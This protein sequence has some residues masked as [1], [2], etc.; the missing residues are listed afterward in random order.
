MQGQKDLLFILLTG[1]MEVK[2]RNVLWAPSLTPRAVCTSP[3]GSWKLLPLIIPNKKSSRPLKATLWDLCLSL[4]GFC[5][6]NFNPQEETGLG[7]GHCSLVHTRGRGGRERGEP[8]NEPR[9]L[10]GMALPSSGALWLDPGEQPIFTAWSALLNTSPGCVIQ[11]HRRRSSTAMLPL[12]QLLAHFG[13]GGCLMIAQC[14]RFLTCQWH[15][16][17]KML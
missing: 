11:I 7:Q 9:C 14:S 1:Q 5:G 16:G 6:H 10:E 12:Q 4:A 17:L 3:E 8:K 15:N 13:N 2:N